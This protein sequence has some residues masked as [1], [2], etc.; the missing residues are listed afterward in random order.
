MFLLYIH[1]SSVT[2]AKSSQTKADP[3][4]KV[5][6]GGLVMDFTMKELYAVEQIH[7]EPQLFRLIV[8]LVQAPELTHCV[9]VRHRRHH[10]L[11]HVYA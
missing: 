10:R 1:A 4:D 5:P 9:M 11:I 8:G 7:S 2:S 3:D 6:A